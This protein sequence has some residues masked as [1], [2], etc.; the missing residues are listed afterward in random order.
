MKMVLRASDGGGRLSPEGEES[1]EKP[2]GRFGQGK[3]AKLKVG[4]RHTRLGG[5]QVAFWLA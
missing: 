3:G 1:D 5:G 2:L 4:G